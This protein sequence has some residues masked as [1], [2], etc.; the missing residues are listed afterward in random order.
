MADA[1]LSLYIACYLTVAFALLAWMTRLDVHDLNEA[2]WLSTL[3][4]V[5]LMVLLIVSPIHR[6]GWV[7]DIQYRQDLSPF[8]FRRRPVGGPGW[9][10]RCLRLELQVWKLTKEER[11]GR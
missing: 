2:F 5:T 9:A 1:P 10:V 3:W 11:R 8:G 6:M 4:P 7:F